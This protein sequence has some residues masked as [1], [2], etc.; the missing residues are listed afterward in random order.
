MF[1]TLQETLVNGDWSQ[2]TPAMLSSPVCPA[3]RI[4]SSQYT[5]VPELPGNRPPSKETAITAITHTAQSDNFN[6]VN[7]SVSPKSSDGSSSRRNVSKPPWAS[8]R[9]PMAQPKKV[10]EVSA[11]HTAKI[12]LIELAKKHAIEENE[13]LKE[14]RRLRLQQEQ[15]KVKQEQLQTEL[16]TLQVLK[17]KKE[18]GC[19]Q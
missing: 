8:R 16:L 2:Y 12:E 5:Q 13:A 14:V 1:K 17:L 7:T 3:L 10:A 18:L 15:E 6:A 19:L 4:P 9:R 11:L